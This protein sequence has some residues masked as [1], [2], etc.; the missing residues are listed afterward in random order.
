MIENLLLTAAAAFSGGIID[1]SA[2][3]SE[4]N[5]EIPLVLTVPSTPSVT[6]AVGKISISF[7]LSG[8]YIV[9]RDP[10]TNMETKF[11]DS[12]VVYINPGES[13]D[14]PE[15]LDYIQKEYSE[16]DHWADSS[17]NFFNSSRAH[18]TS[19][20]FY[21]HWNTDYSNTI[22]KILESTTVNYVYDETD[23]YPYQISIPVLND[24]YKNL[25]FKWLHGGITNWQKNGSESNKLEDTIIEVGGSSNI[26]SNFFPSD[27]IQEALEE[28]SSASSYGGCGPIAMIGCLDYFARYKNY[29][30]LE[31]KFHSPEDKIKLA[32]TVFDNTPTYEAGVGN[33]QT[34]TWPWDY[35]IGFSNVVNALGLNSNYLEAKYR[36]SYDY[37]KKISLIKEYID[38]DIPVTGYGAWNGYGE[39]TNHYFNIYSYETWTGLDAKG[40]TV[41]EIILG[42]RLNYGDGFDSRIFINSKALLNPN[43]TGVITYEADYDTE[44][45]IDVDFEDEFT[46]DS[47]DELYNL[48]NVEEIVETRLSHYTFLTKRLRCGYVDGKYLV[49]SSRTMGGGDAYLEIDFGSELFKSMWFSAGIWSNREY[50]HSYQQDYFRVEAEINNEWIVVSEIDIDQMKL[51]EEMSNY[52]VEFGS[53]ISKIRF[54]NHCENPA[55]VIDTGRIV[56]GAMQ[57]FRL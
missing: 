52:L 20:T 49:L 57:F 2:S 12:I 21:A 4:I 50:L 9:R 13:L 15:E 45:I 10:Y 23:D 11:H 35:Q 44:G 8:G 48:S 42:I 40:K 29:V 30:S 31:K 38:K 1:N 53:P 56:L 55:G 33:K 18:F 24:Y 34:L 51:K 28:S 22:N 19:T 5:T 3:F 25:Y 26:Y 43:F 17:G 36:E 14:K 27:I 16:F 37:T 47:S 46:S 54:W 32:K 39:I 41:S 6:S 7:N